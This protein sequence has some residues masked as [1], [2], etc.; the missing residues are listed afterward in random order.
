MNKPSISDDELNKILDKLGYPNNAFQGIPKTFEELVT[1][2]KTLIAQKDEEIK[3][4]KEENEQLLNQSNELVLKLRNE[5]HKYDNLKQK[6]KDA[7]DKLSSKRITD[8]RRYDVVLW[9]DVRELEKEL[10]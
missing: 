9:K 7:I 4:L 8:K 6:V 10:I 3:K 1:F 5:I 2:S